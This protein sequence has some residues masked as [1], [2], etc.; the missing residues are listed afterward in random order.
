MFDRASYSAQVAAAFALLGLIVPFALAAVVGHRMSE[1]LRVRSGAEI[2]GMA[3]QMAHQLDSELNDV[4]ARTRLLAGSL[5]LDADLDP[6]AVRRALHDFQ[7]VTPEI[8]WAGFARPDGVVAAATDG[9][10]EGQ[11]I[12]HR[13]VFREATDAVFLGGLHPAK[14]LDR[15]LGDPGI[16]EPLRF[17]DVSAPVRDQADGSLQGV[18]ATH[19]SWAWAGHVRERLLS[20]TET[21]RGL[22]FAILGPEGDVL[23]GPTPPNPTDTGGLRIANVVQEVAAAPKDAGWELVDLAA[24]EDIVASIQDSEIGLGWRV[25]AWQPADLAFAPANQAWRLTWSFALIAALLSGACGWLLGRRMGAPI[26]RIAAAADGVREGRD[27]QLPTVNGPREVATL[28]GALGDLLDAL[29]RESALQVSNAK[30]QRERSAAERA[31]RAK[32][33]FLANMNHE[34]RTPLN[35]VMGFAQMMRHDTRAPLPN[36]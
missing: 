6:A 15:H 8:A 22:A 10:L 16:Q 5:Q 3:R 23:L 21:R 2:A 14:L 32:S 34:L 13:P 11:S 7:Q 26:L 29:Q 25:L 36:T 20:T 18:V 28:A 17:L 35:A 4:R 31:S 19:V 27:K 24:R 33:I 12:R 9:L 30:L 1:D